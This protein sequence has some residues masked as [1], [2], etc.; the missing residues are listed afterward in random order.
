MRLLLL[1][2]FPCLLT[3]QTW[4]C[5]A[6]Q[7]QDG[8]RLS[9]WARGEEGKTVASVDT[10]LTRRGNAFLRIDYDLIGS[11]A[12]GSAEHFRFFATDGTDTVRTGMIGGTGSRFAY[13]PIKDLRRVASY[14][15]ERTDVFKEGQ[16]RTARQVVS[17]RGT[18]LERKEPEPASGEAADAYLA[19]LIEQGGT[20]DLNGEA[21]LLEG[22][23][24]ITRP[25]T[26]RNGIIYDTLNRGDNRGNRKDFFYVTAD[27]TFENVAVYGTRRD[28]YSLAVRGRTTVPYWISPHYDGG[29]TYRIELTGEGTQQVKLYTQGESQPF[30]TRTVTLSEV[31]TVIKFLLPDPMKRLDIEANAT[32]S[33]WGTVNHVYASEFSSAWF[34]TAGRLTL[35]DCRAYSIMGDAFQID[36]DAYAVVDNFFSNGTSRQSCSVNGG[37]AEIHN[38]EFINSGRSNIDVEPYTAEAEVHTLILRDVYVGNAKFAGFIGNNWAQINGLDVDGLFQIG[39]LNDLWKGGGVGAKITHVHGRSNIQFLGRDCYL[40]DITTHG[41]VTIDGGSRYEKFADYTGN[42]TLVNSTIY[43]HASSGAVLNT[44]DSTNT[45]RGVKMLMADDYTVTLEPS[46]TNAWLRGNG[47]L[48]DVTVEDAER[49]FSGTGPVANPSLSLDLAERFAR[50]SPEGKLQP[51]TYYYRMELLDG[52][53]AYEGSVDMSGNTIKIGIVGIT[54]SANKRVYRAFNLYRG[55]APGKYDAVF[56]IHP[57]EAY[58][59]W[60][61]K[62]YLIDYGDRIQ[63][64]GGNETENR[65]YGYRTYYYPE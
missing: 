20:V 14:G 11:T 57:T 38:S 9:L 62:S 32:V 64:A 16:G 3:A 17:L 28:D 34:A 59:G 49:Y 46:Q 51:V 36:K 37:G 55:T 2:L 24:D 40:N 21:Y 13:L 10:L 41:N 15:I 53:V 39:E 65:F 50:K 8:S 43:R 63:L 7:S 35:T 61:N 56:R 54:D 6:C 26:V 30:L 12:G 27:A 52:T 5:V 31:P 45:I 25:V 47:K 4:D 58:S 44:G 18:R 33:V 48:E 29:E 60:N 19:W 23:I 1:I 22:T 42:N